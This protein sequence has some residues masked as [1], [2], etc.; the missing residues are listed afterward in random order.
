MQKGSFDGA[1]ACRIFL[2]DDMNIPLSNFI[3]ARLHW[4]KLTLPEKLNG[5]SKQ[6]GPQEEMTSS[7]ERSSSFVR[8]L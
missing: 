5:S 1:A 2:V 4:S 6:N 7:L 8:L 3:H